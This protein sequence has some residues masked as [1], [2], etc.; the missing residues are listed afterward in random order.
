MDTTGSDEFD[1]KVYPI[2]SNHAFENDFE[3]VKSSTI[4]AATRPASIKATWLGRLPKNSDIIRHLL[5]SLKALGHIPFCHDSKTT[6]YYFAWLS[7]HTVICFAA[8]LIVMFAWFVFI[9]H[10]VFKK[11]LVF[12]PG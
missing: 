6:G 11:F 9:S 5:K 4:Q 1:K 8:S 10:L 12:G 7:L 2:L 3:V